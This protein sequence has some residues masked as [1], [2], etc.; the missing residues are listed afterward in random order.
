MLLATCYS[1]PPPVCVGV[2]SVTFLYCLMQV[3]VITLSYL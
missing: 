1:S 3:V 2:G